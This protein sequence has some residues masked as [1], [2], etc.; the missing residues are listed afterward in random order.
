MNIKTTR[1]GIWIKLL[2]GTT[3][4][5]AIYNHDLKKSESKKFVLNS[6]HNVC[7]GATI[8]DWG[9]IDAVIAEEILPE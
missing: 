2:K 1:N 3:F 6:D 4:E 8:D 7:L 9:Y 5:T